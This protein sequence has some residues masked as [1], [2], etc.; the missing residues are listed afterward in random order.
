VH[1]GDTPSLDVGACK[2]F[3]ADA[4]LHGLASG[5]DPGAVAVQACVDAINNTSD[6]A[7][8][9]NPEKTAA[10]AFLIPPSQVAVIDASTD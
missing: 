4:C 1:R 5:N 2:R 9:K 3:Y 7:I 6:C 10:C 8:I